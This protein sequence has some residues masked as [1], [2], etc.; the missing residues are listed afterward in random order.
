MRWVDRILG[1]SVRDL[2]GEVD[3]A[4]GQLAQA[5]GL[6]AAARDA[7][8]LALNDVAKAE[9]GVREARDALFREH[10]DLAPDGWAPAGTVS[11]TDQ[12]DLHPGTLREGNMPKNPAWDDEVIHIDDDSDPRFTAGAST[13]SP[14][15]GDPLPPIE[16]AERDE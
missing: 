12:W 13:I 7:L 5:R 3:E 8:D 16:W 10:P 6:E 11:A 9:R 14:V 2:A 15:D 1:R 4:L